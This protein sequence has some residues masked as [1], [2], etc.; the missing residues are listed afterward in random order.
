MD[1]EVGEALRGSRAHI[2][3]ARHAAVLQHILGEDAG[4]GE[5]GKAAVLELRGDR[6]LVCHLER[7]KLEVTRGV[8]RLPPVL[9]LG[10]DEEGVEHLCEQ[11][12]V[13]EDAHRALGH[14]GI[15]GRERGHTL[16]HRARTREARTQ[17]NGD[18]A[19]NSQHG[20]AAVLDLS[21]AQP[22]HVPLLSKVEGVK[23]AAQGVLAGH[24]LELHLHSGAAGDG[25]VRHG[26][27]REGRRRRRER[28]GEEGAEHDAL[29]GR[30][31][32]ARNRV[33]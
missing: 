12:K 13:E 27:G 15:M 9:R 30:A 29:A 17:I 5:H 1:L 23:D 19:D 26:R 10:H 22:H 24:R 31:P 8:V 11:H 20:N 14:H 6:A 25:A 32:R 16:E 2:A 7:V 4:D 3:E 21:L 28:D 18:V 33:N